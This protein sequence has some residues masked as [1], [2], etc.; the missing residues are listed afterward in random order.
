MVYGGALSFLRRRYSRDLTG[1][2]V[3]VSGVPFDSATSNRPGARLGPRAIR[4]ASAMVAELDAFPWGFDPFTRLE[5]VDYGDCL[6]DFGYQHRAVEVI[7]AHADAILAT[8]TTMLT[9]GGD[10]FVTYP[11]LRAHAKVHGPLALVHFDAHSDTWDDDGARLDHGSMFLRAA[12]EGL[13]DPARSVQVG[14]R[15]ANA[16]T[17]GFT[18]VTAPEVHRIGPAAV[19]DRIHEVVGDHRAYLTFDIDCLYPAFAPGTG[20]P[21]PGGLSTAQALEILRGLGGL[22]LVG[23][24]VVEVAP[25]YDHAE[26][27]ALAAATVGHDML[28]LLAERRQRNS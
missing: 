5:V 9:L 24:D 15:S 20:P 1:V 4:A 2:D 21:V 16:D 11:L 8:D 27:T 13:L 22:D 3:A 10:H 25:A 19:L 17:H 23:F 7:E 6:F 26:I 18:I 12:R 28:C 14:I